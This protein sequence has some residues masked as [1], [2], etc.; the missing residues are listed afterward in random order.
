LLLVFLWPAAY[1]RDD[2]LCFLSKQHG[3]I[4]FFLGPALIVIGCNI[5]V[6]VQVSREV[7]HLRVD[8]SNSRAAEIIAKSK[9]A[10]KSSLA[11]GSI[12]GITWVFGLL[13]LVVPDLL[14]FHYIFAFCNA[15]G[16]LWIFCFHLLKDP[17]FRKR[18]RASHLG[19]M[20]G[21]GNRNRKPQKNRVVR[22]K[23]G[24]VQ[25]NGV[26]GGTG[27]RTDGTSD[28]SVQLDNR[29]SGALAE[30]T[31]AGLA[32]VKPAE[33]K[34]DHE[35]AVR[36]PSEDMSDI[37]ARNGYVHVRVASGDGKTVVRPSGSRTSPG[38]LRLP[39]ASRAVNPAPDT[40]TD[41]EG[42]S[43]TSR[44]LLKL[45]KDTSEGTYSAGSVWTEEKDHSLGSAPGKSDDDNHSLA[46]APDEEN[47]DSL[48]SAPEGNNS[49]EEKDLSSPP[50][51][52]EMPTEAA[53]SAMPLPVYVH[54]PSSSEELGDLQYPKRLRTATM[55][56]LW[57]PA[58]AASAGDAIHH[59]NA[60]PATVDITEAH[61]DVAGAQ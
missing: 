2:G 30:T 47:A 55:D 8:R 6:L 51:A 39:V 34:P 9:R 43:V 16:G 31:K 21:S 23:K 36:L 45:W 59:E 3:A 42:D 14:A 38:S 52:P 50:T 25:S 35:S 11:F 1:E 33:V 13:S 49:A 18:A 27:T 53:D 17:E 58:E 32:E 54:P 61:H 40:P 60:V 57:D 48:G 4:W 19:A 41:Q 46:S 29:P 44:K 12:L 24:P 28:G 7:W 37:D 22:R 15:L 56:T 20:L 10:F 5:Y 26:W